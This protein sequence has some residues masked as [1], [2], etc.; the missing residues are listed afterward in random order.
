MSQDREEEKVESRRR[1][2][3]HFSARALGTNAVS[4]INVVYSIFM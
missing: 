1:V 2:A 4:N 3:Q